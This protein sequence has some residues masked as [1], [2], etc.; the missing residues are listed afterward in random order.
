MPSRRGKR[1]AGAVPAAAPP[2][3]GQPARRDRKA[4]TR[5]AARNRAQA[6][7]FWI[8]VGAAVVFA[9]TWWIGISL[10]LPLFGVGTM[11][12]RASGIRAEFL[13]RDPTS[14]LETFYQ[15][16]L[17]MVVVCVAY[18][19][20]LWALRRGF[21]GSFRWAI[22]GCILVG[23]AALPSMPLVSPDTTHFAAD[24][25]TFWLDPPYSAEKPERATGA[26]WLFGKWPADRANSPAY[27]DDPVAQEVVIFRDR[28]SG[29]GPMT[30]AVGG[31]PIP[32]VGDGLR[33]NVLGQKVLSGTLLI[34]IAVLAGL[35]ARRVGGDAGLVTAVIGMN[36][37]FVLE[38]P[39]DGHNDTIMM[40]FAMLA[41]LAII[42]VEG[43]RGRVLGLAAG[44]AAVASKFS[45]IITA[46]V[47]A[48]WWYPRWRP[49][50]ALAFFIAASGLIYLIIQQRGFGSGAAGPLV[51]ISDNTPYKIVQD[52]F[53]F[54][55]S[56]RRTMA[57][58]AYIGAFATTALIMWRHRLTTRQ[59]LLAALGLQMGLFI[60][61]FSP[62]LRF[63]YVLWAFPFIALSGR[64]WLLV[65][66]IAFSFGALIQIFTRQWT[67]DFERSYGIS[68]IESWAV[69][70]MW[71]A[72][73]IAGFA[74]WRVQND[75]RPLFGR[76]ARRA[77]EAHRHGLPG[78]V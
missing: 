70:F 9:F 55:R 12:V 64:P 66:A 31:A 14:G 16:M 48:A 46:P 65:P 61:C 38:F 78:T 8:F 3:A 72:T 41:L 75:R 57:M 39:N 20:A 68:N 43:W 1:R 10:R 7:S 30:Y 2:A 27:I 58:L 13:R 74:S 47:V 71:V 32:F 62:N 53:E 37:L 56:G 50:L 60:F 49:W 36:P 18:L 45:V 40:T 73:L 76:A 6:L 17:V 52:T 34:A 28:P 25:R 35:V 15:V 69:A 29:Y 4:R 59:D 33:A 21:P 44:F 23:I 77:R 42:F 26:R 11:A 63:W 67:F 22:A 51:S 5:A 54:G 24:V 19:V